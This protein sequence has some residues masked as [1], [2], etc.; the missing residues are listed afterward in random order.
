MAALWT[1]AS[2][3]HAFD[4]G[5]GNVSIS[6]LLLRL[7]LQCTRHH[8]T[9]QAGNCTQGASALHGGGTASAAHQREWCKT[10][11][12]APMNVGAG[13]SRLAA[14]HGVARLARPHGGGWRGVL[15]NE[16]LAQFGLAL[17]DC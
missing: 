11:R 12:P 4:C 2:F 13:V 9:G 10:T 14:V 3:P 15:C 6:T 5:A 1:T 16:R 8:I 17:K 7:S